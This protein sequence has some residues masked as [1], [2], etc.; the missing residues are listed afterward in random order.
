MIRRPPRSTL[1]PYTTLFRSQPIVARDPASDEEEVA[2]DRHAGAALGE[3]REG[4]R[5]P[6]EMPVAVVDVEPVL[7]CVGV[8]PELV[9]AAHDVE[10]R[11]PVAVG[12]EEDRV[13]VLG[14]TIRLERRLPAGAERAVAL[15]DEQAAGLPLGAADVDV[16]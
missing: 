10:V 2:R 9:A 5:I 6:V 8:A 1:F 15:L 3:T 13:D 7:E 16:V 11:M 12:V 4:L 14:K